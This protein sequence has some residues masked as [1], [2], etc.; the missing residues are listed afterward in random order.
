MNK[1]KE[2]V[3]FSFWN[4]VRSFNKL[5]GKMMADRIVPDIFVFRMSMIASI[6]LYLIS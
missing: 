6:I 3:F 5:I 4:M 1:C 2:R